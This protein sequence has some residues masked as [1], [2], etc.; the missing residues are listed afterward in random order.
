MGMQ[1]GK[2]D[3]KRFVF[4]SV[5][6]RGTKLCELNPTGEPSGEYTLQG[7]PIPGVQEVGYLP[8]NSHQS[9]DAGGSQGT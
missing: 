6:L 5:P 1:K 7:N 2:S 9:L 3:K 4:K 8:T